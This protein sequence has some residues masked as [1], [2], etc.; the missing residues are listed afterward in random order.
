[1][2]RCNVTYSP[3]LMIESLRKQNASLR[4]ELARYK[5]IEEKV[6]RMAT[7]DQFGCLANIQALFKP[8]KEEKDG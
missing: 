5:E 8:G 4:S 6:M 7:T 1:M 3:N 2:S